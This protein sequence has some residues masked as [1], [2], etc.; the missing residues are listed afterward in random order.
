MLPT[1]RLSGFS[2]ILVL[3]LIIE[4]HS[5]KEISAAEWQTVHSILDE[6]LCSEDKF[7]FICRDDRNHS[8]LSSINLESLKDVD[9]VQFLTLPLYKRGELG[10]REIRW[11]LTSRISSLG[12]FIALSKIKFLQNAPIIRNFLIRLSGVR[13]REKVL[14]LLLGDQF[15]KSIPIAHHI[16]PAPASVIISRNFAQALLSINRDGYLNFERT[17]FALARSSNFSCIRVLSSL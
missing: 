10:F 5:T 1:V 9:L 3:E 12:C 14:E 11:A 4:S 6:F 8:E 7:L 13:R 17:C 2:K 15:R 16:E